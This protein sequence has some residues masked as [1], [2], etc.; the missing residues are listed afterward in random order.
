MN[1]PYHLLVAD[2][3]DALR[4]TIAHA[5]ESQGYWVTSAGSGEEAIAIAKAH[6]IHCA[7]L[8]YRMGD[9]TG[10]DVFLQ[11]RSAGA[12]RASILMTAELEQRLQ[13]QAERLGFSQCL[14]KPVSA[15]LLRNT[16]AEVL[17]RMMPDP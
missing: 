7:I 4:E 12:L 8:D 2:D 1:A 9:M 10:L 3:D 16:V 5:L 14:K 6:F 13:N 17:G 15:H 11:L